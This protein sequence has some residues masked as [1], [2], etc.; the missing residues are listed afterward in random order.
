[1]SERYKKTLS[2]FFMVCS[3]LSSDTF[4]DITGL[5]YYGSTESHLA[6]V[7]PRLIVPED[8]YSFLTW[9]RKSDNQVD[10]WIVS[11]HEDWDLTLVAPDYVILEPGTYLNAVRPIL[12]CWDRPGIEFIANGSGCNLCTGSFTVYETVYQPDGSTGAHIDSFAVDFIQYEEGDNSRWV[13][14]SFRL[15]SDIAFTTIPEPGTVLLFGLGGLL[16]KRM[17]KR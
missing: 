12:G 2:L 3:F 4:G 6:T 1:M 9:K 5:Y 14:G 16:L 13:R 8:G 17:K 11:E 7:E 10:F 15:N